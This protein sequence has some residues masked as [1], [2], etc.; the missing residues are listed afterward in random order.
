MA[1]GEPTASRFVVLPNQRLC[2]SCILLPFFL[3]HATLSSIFARARHSA[4]LST[5]AIG[6]QR[7]GVKRSHPVVIWPL[8]VDLWPNPLATLLFKCCA[9]GCDLYAR[10]VQSGEA[11][12][13]PRVMGEA[14]ARTS[15][16]RS[17]LALDLLRWGRPRP[18]PGGLAPD[19]VR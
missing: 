3:Q 17:G 18:G 11:C 8:W 12:P 19:I 10:A 13:G 7:A 4:P 15:Y 2:P 5:R 16:D 9:I 14:S 1:S 6:M